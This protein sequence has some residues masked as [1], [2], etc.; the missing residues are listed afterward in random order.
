MEKFLIQSKDD[1]SL[2]GIKNTELFKLGTT[3]VVE[4]LFT[5]ADNNATKSTLLQSTFN[6]DKTMTGG[7][8]LGAGKLYEL[9]IDTTFIKDLTITQK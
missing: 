1:N 8:A 7:S 4:D 9:E 3:N 5:D 6:Y 2:Y